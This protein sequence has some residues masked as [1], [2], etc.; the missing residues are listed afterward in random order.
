MASLTIGLASSTQQALALQNY[1]TAVLSQN[2]S[3]LTQF[4]SYVRGSPIMIPFDATAAPGGQ[5]VSS[6][7]TNSTSTPFPPPLS[8][9]P[10]LT[11]SQLQLVQQIETSVFALPQA[12][13]AKTFDTSC[14]P[15]RPVYGVLDILQLRLPFPDS[16]MGVSKQAAI[17][18][19]DVASRTVIYS[20]EQV[21]ALPGAA[22]NGTLSTDPRQY[23]TMNNLNHVLLQYLKSIPDVNVARALV[24]FVLTPAVQPPVNGAQATLFGSLSIL[25]LL[26]VAVF[27]SVIPSDVIETVSSLSDPYNNLFFGSDPSH[28]VRD[29]TLVA[30]SRPVIWTELATSQEVVVDS[31]YTNQ[32]F[33]FVWNNASTFF[34]EATNQTVEVG[35][36]T[37]AFRAF[38]LT[39]N[40]TILIT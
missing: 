15:D 31:S 23:G 33:N 19:P 11:S 27:G 29:W 34:H 7:L 2:I 39:S 30:V 10:G 14:Y 21:S 40:T 22:H 17:L 20:G 1:W 18:N 38:G 26:E 9:Y 32:Y 8:C 3:T 25:P 16:R 36:I 28:A 5:N 35:N 4:I 13:V 24:E 37:T 12:S 6:L